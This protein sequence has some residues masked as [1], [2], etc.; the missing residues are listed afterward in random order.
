VVTDVESAG[1][2]GSMYKAR[3]SDPTGTFTLYSGQYQPEATQALSE[4]EPPAYVAVVGKSRTYEPEPGQIFVSIRP[5]T[6]TVVDE[7]TRNQWVFDAAKATWERVKA[8]REAAQA[9]DP[10]AADL[11]K[12]GVAP[13]VADG[14]ALA[15]ER[16]AGDVDVEFFARASADALRFLESG[17]MIPVTPQTPQARAAPAATPKVEG[18]GEEIEETVLDVIR[19]FAAENDKGAQWDAI[20]AEGQKREIDEDTVEEAINALMD[21]GLVYEPILGRLKVT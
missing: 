15:R 14:V 20:V 13:W 11:E 4:I 2:D 17:E 3:I 7:E 5:E 21:K 10:S 8:Y 19:T 16:Y 12:L 18:P 6:V 1:A 9:E